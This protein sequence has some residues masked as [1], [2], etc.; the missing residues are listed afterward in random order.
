M[1]PQPSDMVP[2]SAPRSGQ[3]HGV[4]PHFFETAPPPHVCGGTQLP[5]CTLPP[6]PSGTSPHSAPSSPHV[7][8][9]Q[10]SMPHLL[11]PPTPHTPVR[12]VPQSRTPPHP[13][14]TLPHSAP[15]CWHVFGMQLGT[16]T[17]GT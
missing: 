9:E 15:S 12:H 2:H 4:H 13:S 5:H 1:C 11:R 8:G 6:H 3:V 10:G 7:L 14:G 16:S 17:L